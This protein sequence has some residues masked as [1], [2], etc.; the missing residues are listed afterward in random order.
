M[1]V[2][3]IKGW[4]TKA[5]VKMRS[6]VI[7]SH[8][9]KEA[10]ANEVCSCCQL[11]PPHVPSTTLHPVSDQKKECALFPSVLGSLMLEIAVV[12]S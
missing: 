8:N 12:C 3:F 9:W 10:A 11:R 4:G 6:N 7:G 5:S 2:S 1:S